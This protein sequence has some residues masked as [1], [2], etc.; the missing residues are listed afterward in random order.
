MAV[1]LFQ[2]PRTSFE[3]SATKLIE[4]PPHC[5]GGLKYAGSKKRST[6]TYLLSD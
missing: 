5:F 4:S 2:I 1:H 3:F 6:K